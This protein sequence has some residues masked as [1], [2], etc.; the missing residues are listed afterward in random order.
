MPAFRGDKY[1][2]FR[3]SASIPAALIGRVSHDFNTPRADDCPRTLG[4]LQTPL[5]ISQDTLSAYSYLGPPATLIYP[6]ELTEIQAIAYLRNSGNYD[7][8]TDREWDEFEAN[9]RFE[10]MRTWA[11]ILG[12]RA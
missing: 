11:D 1:H 10:N 5:L 2:K 4:S 7:A 6:H 12:P 8:G 3:A 9:V